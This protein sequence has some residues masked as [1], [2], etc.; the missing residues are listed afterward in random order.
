M[1][2]NITATI[3]LHI[4]LIPRKDNDQV[5]ISYLMQSQ[6]LIERSPFPLF[7]VFVE[8]I[9]LGTNK[10]MESHTGVH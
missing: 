6:L 10:N 5:F 3:L 1:I 4:E 8:A 2:E 7:N 9:K